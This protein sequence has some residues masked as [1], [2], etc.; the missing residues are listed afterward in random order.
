M[1]DDPAKKKNHDG[2]A[3]GGQPD[4]SG[5]GA[6]SETIESLREQLAN[7]QQQIG[8]MGD[9]LGQLRDQL[10]QA[11]AG[12]EPT[13]KPKAPEKPSKSEVPEPATHEEAKRVQDVWGAFA[14]EVRERMWRETSGSTQERKEAIAQ[15]ILGIVR[16]EAPVIPDAL[17]DADDPNKGA[18][19]KKSDL[20]RQQVLAALGRGHTR[21]SV[22]V[23]PSAG[24]VPGV[25]QDPI[26]HSTVPVSG[27]GGVL[28]L[29]DG[30]R[31]RQG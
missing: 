17:F 15:Q 6:K 28:D 2:S 23:S 5:A 21:R 18:T 20:M 16:D 24:A 25:K 14:P 8:K 29:A 11:S 27:G 12:G 4:P 30:I 10:K 26:R 3:D 22:P 9:E 1:A 19:S 13:G 31:R 7:A